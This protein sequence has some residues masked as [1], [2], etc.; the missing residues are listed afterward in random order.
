[1]ILVYYY[2]IIKRKIN[3][4]YLK[5]C[6]LNMVSQT[7]VL[8]VLL[9]C[10]TQVRTSFRHY[11]I[12]QQSAHAKIKFSNYSNVSKTFSAH[13]TLN[14]LANIQVPTVTEVTIGNEISLNTKI[15]GLDRIQAQ[16]L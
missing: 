5:D 4:N 13:F 6:E 7:F 12:T 14:S 15:S 1:M 11:I 3:E 10:T 16:L 9:L 8:N 2:S